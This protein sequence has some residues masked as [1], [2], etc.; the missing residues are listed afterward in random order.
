MRIKHFAGY[1]LVNAQKIS[2]RNFV[3]EYGDKMTEVKIRVRG[4]HERGLEIGN[5]DSYGA[6]NWLLSKFC[7]SLDYTKCSI[8]F[9]T[10]DWYEK[11]GNIDE[12]VCEYTFLI[13]IW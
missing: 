13:R 7:K 8:F 1:G 6:Y 5:W 2:S 9:T 3:N 10:E 11:V 12:E 4:N